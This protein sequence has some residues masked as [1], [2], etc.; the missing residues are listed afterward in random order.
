M[1]LTWTFSFVPSTT[2]NT[3]FPRRFLLSASHKG[4][5]LHTGFPSSAFKSSPSF[6]SHPKEPWLYENFWHWNVCFLLSTPCSSDL[7]LSFWFSFL[8]TAIMNIYWVLNTWFFQWSCMDGRVGLW[9]KLSTKELMLFNCG[10]GEDSW[11]SLGLQGDPTSPFWRR[12]A[13]GFLW[14]E[15]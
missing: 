6:K 3:K 12:S 9:R 10:V 1:P 5:L 8:T 7:F 4:C 11:E 15:W 2:S 13:L 14:R